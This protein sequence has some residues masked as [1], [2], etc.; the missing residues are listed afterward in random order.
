ML[1]GSGSSGQRKESVRRYT[2][3]ANELLA[4]PVTARQRELFVTEFIPM[5]PQ[6]LVTDRVA[7]LLMVRMQV[8]ALVR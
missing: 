3:L 6:G 8:R 4:I 2:E 7:Q 1:T 5:P